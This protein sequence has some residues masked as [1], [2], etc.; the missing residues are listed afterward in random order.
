MELNGLVKRCFRQE[1]EP[2]LHLCILAAEAKGCPFRQCP[3][4]L[5]IANAPAAT[6]LVKFWPEPSKWKSAASPAQQHTADAIWPS[7]RSSLRA[8]KQTSRA[9]AK[10]RPPDN[11]IF[12]TLRT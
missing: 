9:S 3:S 4:A 8:D 2:Y 12:Y 10:I 6:L 1:G 11:C 7:P 5:G